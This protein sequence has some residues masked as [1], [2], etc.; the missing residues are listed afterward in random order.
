MFDFINVAFGWL[1]KWCYIL[2]EKLGFGGYALALLIFAVVCQ[3]LLFPFGIKQQKNSQ[4]QARLRPKENVIRRRYNGRTDRNAQLKMNEEIQNLYAEEHFSPFSGCLPLLIQL[5][6]LFSLF[7][8]IREPLTY[9]SGLDASLILD[10]NNFIAEKSVE[11]FKVLEALPKNFSEISLLNYINSN[12]DAV[13]AQFPE[14]RD[15][16]I[17]NF[18]FTRF[19]DLSL[20]P[21]AFFSKASSWH[22]LLIPVAT[23]LSAYF[24]QKLTRKYT[25]QAPSAESA[26]SMKLMNVMMPLFSAYLS[27]VWE[28]SMGLYWTYRSILSLLQQMILS[29]MFP[30][31]QFTDEELKAQEKEYLAKLKGKGAHKVTPAE[32]KGRKSLIFDDD[33][34]DEASMPDYNEH[35]IVGD[36]E[37]DS[38]PKGSSLIDQAPLKDDEE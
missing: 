10:I 35:S 8:V 9:I 15:A 6:I 22:I 33:D 34:D 32:L 23:F 12:T 4:K 26:S 30:I 27:F 36:D 25:Y 28:A 20:K 2:V 13:I 1:M 11:G 24:G 14:L 3:I 37:D 21:D 17:P 5:P 7:Y 16:L 18:Q 29:K 38:T 31:P 19:I